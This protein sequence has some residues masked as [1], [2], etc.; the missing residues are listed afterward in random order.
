MKNGTLTHREKKI[1]LCLWELNSLGKMP[2]KDG[3]VKILKGKEDKETLLY[4]K[5]VS[6]GLAQSDSSKRIKLA[7]I[8][9]IRE[10]YLE[11]VYAEKDYFLKLA[12]KGKEAYLKDANSLKAKPKTK[13]AIK[14]TIIDVI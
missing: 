6:F 1:I 7:V 10:G 2:S 14:P 8:P 12:L 13:K 4:N 3:L 5:L 11:Q 9:L